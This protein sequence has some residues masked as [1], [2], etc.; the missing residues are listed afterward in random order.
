M[1][2]LTPALDAVLAVGKDKVGSMEDAQKIC[3]ELPGEQLAVPNP[4]D[5]TED[6]GIGGESSSS[7]YTGDFRS[8]RSLSPKP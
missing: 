8:K 6:L 2:I 3:T 4:D 1:M 5:P 7:C